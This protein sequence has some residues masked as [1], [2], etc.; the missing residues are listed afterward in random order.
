[1]ANCQ[2][3]R[4]SEPVCNGTVWRCGSCINVGCDQEHDSE[5]SNQGFRDGVCTR[6]GASKLAGSSLAITP[7]LEQAI[8][9]LRLTLPELAQ[10]ARSRS[11]KHR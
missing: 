2:G 6:C 7:Q 10:H 3:K 1:M 5:C 8:K 9:I 4:K 11:L